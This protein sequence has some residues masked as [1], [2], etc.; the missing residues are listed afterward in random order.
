MAKDGKVENSE[1]MQMKISEIYD[2]ADY[3]LSDRKNQVLTIK[4]FKDGFSISI[5]IKQN[6]LVD[7]LDSMLNEMSETEKK[8]IQRISEGE[9]QVQIAKNLGISQATVSGIK[10]KYPSLLELIGKS[11]AEA[12]LS[13]LDKE[14]ALDRVTTLER[15][16]RELS[17]KYAGKKKNVDKQN[18][19]EDDE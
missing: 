5:E 10:A 19:G 8:V 14:K 4:C 12:A 16:A 7:D 17:E 6:Q 3:V 1:I 9:K 11:A 13:A 2:S 15:R 18:G